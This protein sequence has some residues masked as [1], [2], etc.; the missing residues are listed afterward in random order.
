MFVLF[1]TSCANLRHFF[2][3][4]TL[5]LAILKWFLG[6][7]FEEKGKSAHVLIITLFACLS[8]DHAKHL[9]GNIDAINNS[10]HCQRYNGPKV[11]NNLTHSIPL[12]QEEASTSFEILVK[13]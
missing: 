3:I 13:L 7:N 4:F 9:G 11:I 8:H 12:V 2:S 1:C 10:K 5:V 6:A